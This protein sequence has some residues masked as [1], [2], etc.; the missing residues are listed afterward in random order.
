[1]CTHGFFTTHNIH[2]APPRHYLRNISELNALLA[3]P[4]STQ[5]HL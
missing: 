1:M 3:L 2:H 5:L 4:C